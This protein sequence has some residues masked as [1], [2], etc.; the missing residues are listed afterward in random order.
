M[1]FELSRTETWNRYC[2]ISMLVEIRSKDLE[3]LTTASVS[4]GYPLEYGV[5]KSKFV[6]TLRFPLRPVSL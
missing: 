5:K 3:V 1:W 6:E 2:K 4:I